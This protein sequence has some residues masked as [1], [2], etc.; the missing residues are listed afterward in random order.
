MI[1]YIYKLL[2]Y[3]DAVKDNKMNKNHIHFLM[4]MNIYN[5]SY[6][7]IAWEELKLYSETFCTEVN[8]CMDGLIGFERVMLC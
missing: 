7:N 6:K 3:I 1:K 2:S 4:N 5:W 8:F